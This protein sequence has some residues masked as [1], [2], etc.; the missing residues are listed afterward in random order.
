MR[1][2]VGVDGGGTKTDAVVGDESGRLLGLGHAGPA[3]HAVVGIEG[4]GQAVRQAIDAALKEAGASLDQVEYAVLGLAGADFPEDFENLTRSVRTAVAGLPFH[5]VN[6]TWIAFRGGADRSW[7]AVVICGT[8][9]NAAARGKNGQE[10]ILRGLTYEV[11]NRGGAVD[12]IRDALHAAFRA[13][14]GLGPATA[15][16]TVVLDTLGMKSYDDLARTIVHAGPEGYF[17]A[18]GLAPAVFNLANQGDRVAQDI[19]VS[20]GAAL[21]E[22]AAAV[23][24]RTGLADED[25]EVV[26]AGSLWRGVNPLMRDQFLTTLHRTAPRA[27]AHLPRYEP[28]VGAYIMA[29]DHAGV[30]IDPATNPGLASA[31]ERWGGAIRNQ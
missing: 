8:G 24:R 21:G 26:L 12:I 3:N 23:I 7:G 25:V 9:V 22:S 5:V 2:F 13:H 19:L 16:E 28:V 4:A 29:L 15:L 18:M 30:A 6:D 20:H 31:A 14:D 17:L 10:V 27:W 1:Y 11:G